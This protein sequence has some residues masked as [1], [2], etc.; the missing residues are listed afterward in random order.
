MNKKNNIVEEVRKFVEEIFALP[1]AR[2]KQSYKGHF[3]P[4]VNY[5]RELA[6][7]KMLDNESKEVL[8]IAAWL[9][10]IGSIACGRENHHVTGA[11]IA[12]KKLKELNYPEE[13]IERVKKCILNH[14]GSTE[15]DNQRNSVE[16]NILV[17][18]D[19]MSAFDN[20]LGLF[21][22]AFDWE[23]L[24][25]EQARKSVREKLIRK[26]NQLSLEGKKLVKPK[27]EAAMLLLGDVNR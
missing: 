12:E 24:D 15:K 1:E 16:E 13:K 11:E 4:V 21:R 26:Y 25:D 20:I 2:Y 18:V 17:E 3:I 6:K 8:E 19:V 7:E 10:D 5:S 22:A 23:D 27:Y 9:H 14:R